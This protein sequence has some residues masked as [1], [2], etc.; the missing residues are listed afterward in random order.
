MTNIVRLFLLGL[1]T[2][3]VPFVTAFFFMDKSGSLSIN[4]FLFKTIMILTG[5]ITGAIALIL[6]FKK[7]ESAY[8]KQGFITGTVWFFINIVLDLFMLIPMS[9]M[10][11]PDYFMQIGLR[12]LMIP[13]MALLVGYLLETKSSKSQ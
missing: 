12:Y 1:I 10:S 8:F 2:W 3:I 7:I 9:K 11:Y 13:I 6:F 5:G 4:V